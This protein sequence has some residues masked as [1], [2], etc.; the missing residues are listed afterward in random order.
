MTPEQRAAEIVG[1]FTDDYHLRSLK[2]LESHDDGV[3]RMEAAIAAALRPSEAVKN[4][5]DVLDQAINLYPRELSRVEDAL[6]IAR[7]ELGL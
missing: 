3:Q 4:L 5:I 7:K 1:S 6:D 2:L